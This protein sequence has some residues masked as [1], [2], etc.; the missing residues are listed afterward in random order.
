MVFVHIF[1]LETDF[2]ILV[3]LS[4][5]PLQ[6]LNFSCWPSFIRASFK[7]LTNVTNTWEIELNEP[8]MSLC[9]FYAF[10]SMYFL[11]IFLMGEQAPCVSSSTW[12]FTRPLI[13]SSQVDLF[14]DDAWLWAY[15]EMNMLMLGQSEFKQNLNITPEPGTCPMLVLQKHGGKGVNCICSN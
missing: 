2:T 15:K 3:P 12:S 1:L 13:V 14:H 8:S 9:I 7:L 11:D 10:L 6:Y 4:S 5:R